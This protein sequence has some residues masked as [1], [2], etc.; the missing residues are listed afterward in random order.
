MKIVGLALM[1][2]LAGPVGL[3]AATPAAAAQTQNDCETQIA[4][5]RTA[6]GAV[7]ISGKNA[8]QDRASLTKTLNAAST[9]LA[10]GKNADAVKK[11]GDFKV[12]VGQLAEAGRISNA[13]AAPLTAGA[14]A[15][16]ACINGLTTAA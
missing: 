16:I 7:A 1:A 13:D 14:D 6:S 9:E 8:D 3:V 12:K 5:L 4:S 15:A 11:L 2:A 10:K